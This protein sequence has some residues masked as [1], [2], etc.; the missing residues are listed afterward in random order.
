MQSFSCAC[1]LYLRLQSYVH[2][3]KSYHTHANLLGVK[4]PPYKITFIIIGN[5][6]GC[7]LEARGSAAYLRC[8]WE[9]RGEGWGTEAGSEW[10]FAAVKTG[11]WPRL[12]EGLLLRPPAEESVWLVE[13]SAAVAMK[14]G[15]RQPC[16]M[17]NKNW[18]KWKYTI[19]G[20]VFRHSVLPL[21]MSYPYTMIQWYRQLYLCPRVDYLDCVPPV[22][23]SLSIWRAPPELSF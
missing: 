4:I 20:P 14:P 12:V 10:D 19:L 5:I 17:K 15:A 2:F 21:R 16:L 23:I 8:S 22:L 18:I 6:G 13:Q 9:S 1:K 3:H 11:A 7:I